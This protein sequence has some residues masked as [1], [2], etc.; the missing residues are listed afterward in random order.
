MSA[1]HKHLSTLAFLLPVAPALPAQLEIQRIQWGFDGLI[2]PNGFNLLTFELHNG[3]DKP[4]AGDVDLSQTSGI[5]R[6]GASQRIR[7]YLGPGDSRRLQFYPYLVFANDDWRVKLGHAGSRNIKEPDPGY[8]ATVILMQPDTLTPP[9]AGLPTFDESR[10]PPSVT[11]TDGLAR[12]ILDHVPA[13]QKSQRQAFL[14][15]LHRGG[16]V[17]LCPDVGG[18]PRFAGELSVL[19]DKQSIFHVG[20]GRVVRHSE[21][22]DRLPSRRS[23]LPRRM[24]RGSSYAGSAFTEDLLNQMRGIVRP[25]HNWPLIYFVIVLFFIAAVPWHAWMSFQKW[26]YVGSISALLGIVALCTYALYQIGRRGYGEESVVHA[27]SY[28]RELTPGRYDTTQFKNVFVTSGGRYA[29]RHD[30]EGSIYSTAQRIEPVPGVAQTGKDALFRVAIPV[31]TSRPFVHRGVFQAPP[32]G[33]AIQN[34]PETGPLR[35]GLSID[36]SGSE[37]L[38]AFAFH[39]KEVAELGS[40]GGT[41]SFARTRSMRDDVLKTRALQ[42]GG[43]GYAW[44]RSMHESA[45]TAARGFLGPILAHVWGLLAD[46][47]QPLDVTDDD[48]IRLVVLSRAPQSFYIQQGEGGGRF[49]AEEGYVIYDLMLRKEK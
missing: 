17:H 24:G 3:T 46:G 36:W 15:W 18:P 28:A 19:N 40:S 20:S 29:I 34:W 5:S 42:Q 7:T 33:A 41:L 12:V 43:L 48:S 38:A 39:R 26:G 31:F 47:G 16:E 45:E 25:D 22:V 21:R 37:V 32:T 35:H 6:T 44:G 27:L 2:V 30:A 13:F 11:G 4:F 8:P 9:R 23:W 10:F 1:I 49:G 14:D